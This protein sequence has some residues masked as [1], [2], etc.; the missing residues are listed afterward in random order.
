MSVQQLTSQHFTV[1]GQQKKTLNLRAGGNVMVLF[2]MQNCPGCRG[3]EPI[4]HQLAG[5][6]RYPVTYATI[7]VGVYRDVAARSKQTTAPI[8]AVPTIILY[9]DG[10]PYARIKKKDINSAKSG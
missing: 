10:R 9:I 5:E 4:L 1:T 8:T 3:F 2:K 7:D 6:G